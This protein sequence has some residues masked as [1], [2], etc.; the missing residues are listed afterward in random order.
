M[1][2][3]ISAQSRTKERERERER[4]SASEETKLSTEESG[5]GF[6][7]NIIIVVKGVAASDGGRH[8]SPQEPVRGGLGNRKGESGEDFPLQPSHFAL[9]YHL[10]PCGAVCH[11]QRYRR[12]FCKSCFLPPSLPPSL[13]PH[14]PTSAACHAG[15]NYCITAEV[16]VWLL[17]QSS[18][19][20][21]Y[22]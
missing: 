7:Q 2:K 22:E 15:H 3:R 6:D 19:P 9:G 8:G 4:A 20:D 13:S 10:W 12:G 17:R 21:V 16:C 14:S 18:L 11:L 1:W 5:L